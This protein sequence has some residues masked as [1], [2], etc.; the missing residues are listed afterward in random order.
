ME[1]NHDE[2]V[3]KNSQRS[4]YYRISVELYTNVLDGCETPSIMEMLDKGKTLYVLECTEPWP[5]LLDKEGC[6]SF[7]HMNDQR[8]LLI[9]STMPPSVGDVTT[10]MLEDSW[11][12]CPNKSSE[13]LL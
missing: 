6:V 2:I 7:R 10:I 1:R 12:V 9:V 3:A 4:T 13:P 5:N 11:T 8:R